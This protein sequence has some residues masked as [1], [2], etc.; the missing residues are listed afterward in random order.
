MT[1]T[2]PTE[3]PVDREIPVP[4]AAGDARASESVAGADSAMSATR[5]FEGSHKQSADI[6]QEELMALLSGI[7]AKGATREDAIHGLNAK[8]SY[9]QSQSTDLQTQYGEVNHR[10]NLQNVALQALQNAVSLAN[11]VQ[12]AAA[13]NAN[14]AAKQHL[15]HRDIATDRTWNVDEQAW[16]VTELMRTNTFKEAVS[17]AVAEAVNAKK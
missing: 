2:K 15:A 7:A 10:Q 17:A 4:R 11:S 14:F 3:T 13:E 5:A 9:D 8:R 6:N 12:V 16:A 1:M